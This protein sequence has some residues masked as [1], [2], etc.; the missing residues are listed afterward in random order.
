[1]K[2]MKTML[3]VTALVLLSTQLFATRYAKTTLSHLISS[4]THIVQGEVVSVESYWKNAQRNSIYTRVMVSIESPIKGEVGNMVE[5]T[6]R[7]GSIGE[8]S[9]EI[10]DTPQLKA[11][12][13]G[14][15]FLI[16]HRDRYWIHSISLGYYQILE[17]SNAVYNQ[18]GTSVV[19]NDLDLTKVSDAEF[20]VQYN[21]NEFL[22]TVKVYITEAEGN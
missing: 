16:Q 12:D 18:L 10:E 15:F 7:G 6:L 4:S 14:I 11:G 3:W 1:M 20:Q 8:F 17:E 13:K 19:E 21:Y 22:N 5:I 9:E 2:I